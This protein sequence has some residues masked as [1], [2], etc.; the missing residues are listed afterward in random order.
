MRQNYAERI[1]VLKTTADKHLNGVFDVVHAGAG[2]PT[3]A[4]LKT[5]KSDYAAQQAQK[6][7][8]EV[9]PLSVFTMKHEQPPALMLGFAGCNPA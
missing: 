2:I 5:W 6:L 7:G 8:L 9:I 4:W 3:L 1:D